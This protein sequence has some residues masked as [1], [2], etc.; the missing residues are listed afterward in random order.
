[1]DDWNLENADRATA[2]LAR[3]ASL[4]EAYE[5]FWRYGARDFR[6]IGHKAIYVANS[7]RTLVTI[8]WRHAEPILRSLTYALLDAGGDANPARNEHAADQPGRDNLRK[9]T[10][11]RADWQRGE[12]TRDAVTDLLATMRTASASE[13]ADAV[14]TKLNARV[15][16]A[17]VWDALFL[18]A[19]ELLM[20]QPGIVGLHTVT[21]TNALAFGFNTT[22]SD[23]TRRFLMLQAASFLT[24][25]RARMGMLPA[26]PRIDT[27]EA[28]ELTGQGQAAIDN[29]FTTLQPNNAARLSAARKA[30]ALAQNH[31]DQVTP[32]LATARRLIF[33]K[34]TDSHDYK[35]SSAALEDFNNVSPAWRDRYLASSVFWLKGSGGND[36][37]V[38]QRTRAALANG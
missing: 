1:M 24:M 6:D 20:K 29:I 12:V 16:P 35:F 2:Q 3:V 5:M 22:S 23:E 11:I 33:A 17:C 31:R 32:M 10:R 34:G 36:A 26:T 25:F 18:T 7:Y 30:F 4:N 37:P 27:L 15:D 38:L 19:G 21:T 8:G 13:A 9:L 28:G 14:V